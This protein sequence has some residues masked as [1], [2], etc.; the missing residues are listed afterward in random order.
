MVN[1]QTQCVKEKSMSFRLSKLKP[2]LPVIAISLLLA[3]CGPAPAQPVNAAPA[4]QAPAAAPTATTAPAATASLAPT[5]APA[6][7]QAPTL[8]QAPAPTQA[9]ATQPTATQAAAGSAAVSYAKDVQPIFDKSCVKCHGGSNGVQSGLSLASYA[10]LMK[11]GQDGAVVIPGDAAN[12]ML[13][14]MIVSGKMPKRALKLPQAE[15][16]TISAWVAAGAKNN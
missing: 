8:T 3:A 13:V 7:T 9:P 1:T 4:T 6:A 15:I 12:S 16:D 14:Q 11:G 2:L 10:D 5:Q